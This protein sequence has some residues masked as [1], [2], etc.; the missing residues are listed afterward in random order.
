MVLHES[1]RIH[2]GTA[3]GAGPYSVSS[4]HLLSCP[5]RNAPHS[6]FGQRSHLGRHDTV[7]S[8]HRGLC[9]PAGRR[10]SPFTQRSELSSSSPRAARHPQGGV[11][12][13]G[14]LLLG[15]GP[16]LFAPFAFS[17]GVP[18]RPVRLPLRTGTSSRFAVARSAWGGPRGG[19]AAAGRNSRRS[20]G[21]S[22][23]SP[24]VASRCPGLSHGAHHDDA[25]RHTRHR[26][27]MIG[28]G[29]RIGPTRSASGAVRQVIRASWPPSSGPRGRGAQAGTE[30]HKQ[31]RSR[32]N[33]DCETSAHHRVHSR[34]PINLSQTSHF[35]ETTQPFKIP[36]PRT[37][38]RTGFRENRRTSSKESKISPPWPEPTSLL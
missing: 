17:V 25:S 24:H 36:I 28:V 13:L 22:S 12:S 9:P 27:C 16:P 1:R 20:D 34:I 33:R 7:T 8:E 23:P 2:T 31:E 3:Y 29:R 19:P 5:S 30:G 4:H 35:L 21:V 38:Y 15:T 37:G 11:S 14:L 32:P 6:L 26:R 10:T 18:V